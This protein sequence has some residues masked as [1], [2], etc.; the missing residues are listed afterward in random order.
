MARQIAPGHALDALFLRTRA[1]PTERRL[2]EIGIVP[3]TRREVTV[4]ELVDDEELAAA[5]V[6]V[7][8][9]VGGA[10]LALTHGLGIAWEG[11]ERRPV[12]VTGHVGV[13]YEKMVD[14]LMTRAGTDLV[15]ANSAYDAARTRLAA[16]GA[17]RL[18]ALRPYCSP[19]RAGAYLGGILERNGL[20]ER[21]RPLAL[22]PGAA[23]TGPLRTVIRRAA[24]SG[25]KSLYRVGRERVAPALRR[26]GQH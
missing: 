22:V 16:L 25:A 9:T 5:D 18:P 24:R 12:T 26:W 14:G 21:G 3:D 23:G 20:D 1:T 10:T 19:Q 17:G 11:R 2:E 8:A 4:A 7:L 15:L 13:V 6:A